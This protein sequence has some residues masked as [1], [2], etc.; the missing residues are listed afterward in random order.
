MLT[1]PE[2]VVNKARALGAEE[3]LARLPELV[4]ELSSAWGVAIGAVYDDAT[5]AFVCEATSGVERLVLKIP[6]PRADAT[7][8]HEATVLRFDDGR[9]CARLLREDAATGS[10][11]LER[12]G[13]PL[14]RLDLPLERRLAIL[15]SCAERLWRPAPTL[16]LPSG[17]TKARW[18]SDFISQTWLELEHPCSER[19]IAHALACA[20]R[21]ERAHDPERSVLVHGDVHQWNTLEAGGDFKLIDPDGL[22]AEA[23]YDLGV[24]M[25]EDPLDLLAGDPFARANW[26]AQR[27]GLSARGIWEWGV[28]ERVSTGLLATKVGLQPVGEQML[29]AADHVAVLDREW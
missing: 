5:E 18:L 25:R 9:A 13:T 21:R 16:D 8:L 14:S 23:E 11:L 20:A 7:N 19:S 24:L 3:W 29:L 1:V 6:V 26:L 22:L 4:D 10:L 2:V 12:L 17:A 15:C 27:C 28:V